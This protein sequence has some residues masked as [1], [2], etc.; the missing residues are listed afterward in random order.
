MFFKE[1]LRLNHD[2]KLSLKSM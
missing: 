2:V 1:D